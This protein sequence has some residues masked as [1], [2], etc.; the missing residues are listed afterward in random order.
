[1]TELE[2]GLDGRAMGL[3]RMRGNAHNRGQQ[4]DRAAAAAKC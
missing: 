3:N 2:G 4:Y 1:M